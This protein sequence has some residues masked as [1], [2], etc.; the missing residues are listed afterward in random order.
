M[1]VNTKVKAIAKAIIVGEH[2]VVYGASAIAM[3]ITNLVLNMDLSLNQNTNHSDINYYQDDAKG[4]INDL[5]IQGCSLLQV[6]YS[7]C[8]FT[9]SSNIPI[10]C[11]LGSSAALCVSIIKALNTIFN[12]SLSLR[13]ICH[14]AN[15][16]ERNFH[17][18]PSGLDTT[19]VALKETILFKKHE[20]QVVNYKKIITNDFKGW[21][22]VLINS[23]IGVVTKSMVD[24]VKPYFQGAN[25]KKLIKEFEYI[26]DM[27]YK[28]LVEGDI[29]ALGNRLKQA[30]TLLSFIGVVNKELDEILKCCEECEVLGAKPTGAGG[31]GCI[32]ALLNPYIYQEQFRQLKS[33]L[34]KY[35][36]FE[37]PLI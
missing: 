1:I 6:P 30:S 21:P 27:V 34:D 4:F 25:G 8:S 18:N 28:H 29:F 7:N 36:I 23:G 15:I 24:L 17:G 13:E 35:Y 16:L 22:F 12:R 9:I 26:T 19:V 11:G 2:A 14:F 37:I 10:G 5:I 33:K 3:P 20:Y 32:L 31:G